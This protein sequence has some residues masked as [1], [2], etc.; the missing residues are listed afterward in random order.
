MRPERPKVEQILVW[1]GVVAQLG[2][3]R[4]NAILEGEIPYPLYVLLNHFCH[5]P[6]REWTVTELAA[7]FESPAP[8][9][10]KNV[11]RLIER[12]WLE[13]RFD[14][15]DGRVKRLRVTA[16]GI[17][18]RDEAAARVLPD[19]LSLF[20]DFDEGEV[21]QLHALLERLKTRMD[22]SREELVLPR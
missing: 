15:S 4:V 16:S 21:A 11:R 19:R 6:D 17:A 1:C 5:D 8:G 22:E 9:I 18:V 12:G 2:R 13:W 14:G 7:A 20:E 10:S 3:T